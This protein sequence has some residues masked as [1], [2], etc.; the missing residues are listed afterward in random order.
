MQY[1]EQSFNL[2]ELKGLSP[3]Q[4]EVHLKLYAGYVKNVNTMLSKIEEWK[5]DS[6]K[7]ALALS[8][9]KRRF[10]FEFNG[11]RLHEIYFES[12]GGDGQVTDGS[13]TSA[14]AAQYGSVEA[15]WGEFTALGMM[16][17]IGW[18]LLCYDKKNKTFHTNWVSDHE[19]GHLATTDIL[20]AMD[21]W[22]HAFMVD[23]VP[24]QKGDYVKAFL[25]N[26]SWTVIEERFKA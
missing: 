13:L 20:I 11:M 24:A 18:V 19:L 8:E 25:Q 22:E 6:E 7:N 3:K 26:L 15:F 16:R 9:I 1:T 17:G 10:P 12:L 21:M 5:G 2:P 4:L 14:L 23:Y